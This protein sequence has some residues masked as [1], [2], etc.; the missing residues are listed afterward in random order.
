MAY[1]QTS[2]SG[3]RPESP[4]FEGFDIAGA[5][6]AYLT[7]A[8]GKLPA[9][10][11]AMAG[12]QVVYA[13]GASGDFSVQLEGGIR[14]ED[15]TVE[16]G[17]VISVDQTEVDLPFTWEIVPGMTYRVRHISGADVVALVN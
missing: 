16:Y 17:N 7:R 3:A 1:Q 4:P 2:L 11:I 5:L 14:Q 10:V 15:G 6:N 13:A 9:T 12:F 8:Q